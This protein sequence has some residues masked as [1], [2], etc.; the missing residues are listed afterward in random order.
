MIDIRST[1]IS[2]EIVTIVMTA[3][4]GIAEVITGIMVTITDRIGTIAIIAI[5]T[6]IEDITEIIVEIMG[7]TEFRKII[8]AAMGTVAE[9]P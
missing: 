9:L 6:T 7:F 5:A 8:A 3:I 2:I 1:G 4:V